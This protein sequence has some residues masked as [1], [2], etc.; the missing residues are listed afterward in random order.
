M[1]TATASYQGHRYPLE[2]INHSVWLCFRFS[3]S[4]R[5][6]EDLMLAGGVVTVTLFENCCGVVGFGAVVVDQL[7][8]VGISGGSVEF[9]NLIEDRE[10][11]GHFGSPSGRAEPMASGPTVCGD[12]AEG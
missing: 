10:A 1:S 8:V 11:V 5:E 3:L 4:F 6:V 2:I 7:W 12:P 9:G